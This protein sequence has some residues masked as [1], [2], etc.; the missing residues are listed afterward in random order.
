MAKELTHPRVRLYLEQVERSTLDLPWT[1][2]RALLQGIEEQLARRLGR[3]PTDDDVDDALRQLGPPERVAA[4]EPRTRL[5][6]WLGWLR[7]EPG[8]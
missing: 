7:R 3:S 4:A 8:A 6:S 1:Q 2:R 5:P